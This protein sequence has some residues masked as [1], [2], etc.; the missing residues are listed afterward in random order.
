[1]S[2]SQGRGCKGEGPLREQVFA[3]SPGRAAQLQIGQSLCG[4]VFKKLLLGILS[5]LVF[6]T[7]TSCPTSG[8]VGEQG[9][10]VCGCG[11]ALV[12]CFP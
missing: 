9:M 5:S 12:L 3:A 4:K 8:S 1:M 2:P 7:V 6:E 11:Q 10:G